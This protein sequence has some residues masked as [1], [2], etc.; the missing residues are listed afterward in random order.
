MEISNKGSGS[1]LVMDGPSNHGSPDQDQLDLVV[2]IEH[3]IEEML[4]S[5]R[6][7]MDRLDEKSALLIRLGVLSLVGGIG[8][9]TFLLQAVP[10]VLGWTLLLILV[11]GAGWNLLGIV[12][13][14][15]SYLGLQGTTDI[16]MGPSAK[17]LKEKSQDENWTRGDLARSV[18]DKAPTYLQHNTRILK[19]SGNFR[20][21]GWFGLLIAVLFYSG[22]MIYIAVG[23]MNA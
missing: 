5:Q 18:A 22:T 2:E 14:L 3:K 16:A 15:I 6:Q 7:T 13:L 11:S 10:E 9:V 1:P 12:L 21:L 17:W 20:T 4:K 8:I 19:R 23:V